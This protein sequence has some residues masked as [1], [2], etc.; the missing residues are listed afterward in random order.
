MSV[1]KAGTARPKPWQYPVVEWIRLYE[2]GTSTT[3]IASLSNVSY[4][5]VVKFLRLAGVPLRGAKP[6]WEDV[7]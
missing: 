5:T 3:R 4:P 6:R 7:Q 2:A 1:S